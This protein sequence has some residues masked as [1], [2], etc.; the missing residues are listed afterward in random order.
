M[1]IIEVR[2][3]RKIFKS[4]ERGEGFIEATRSLFRRKKRILKAVNNVD[5]SIN[6]GEIVGFLGPNGA[7]KSTTIKIMSGVMYPDSGSVNIMGYVPWIDRK[8]YVANIGVVFG[9][10]SQLFWDLPPVDSFYLHKSIFS[11]EDDIFKEELEKLTKLLSI[12]DIMKKPTRQLS[13][14][15]RMRCEFV[16]AM[17]HK[18]RIVF[19]DEP[20]IGL[21]IFAKEIIRKFIKRTNK[22]EGTTFI[23]TSH[24]LEDIEHLCDRVIVINEGRIVF[25]D[26]T[27]KLKSENR[28]YVT[29]KFYN[30]VNLSKVKKIKNVK[31]IKKLSDYSL[32][33]E[34]DTSKISLNEII[35]VFGNGKKI[36]DLDISNPPITETIK[37]LYR[38]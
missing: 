35:S 2:E 18:P 14:G 38:A 17:L 3:L 11:V 19:L 25:N 21:D 24:D 29:I 5:F 13:L 34:V 20:T 28:K 6:E 23:I 32:K 16:M 1:K 31:I 22:K 33:L 8:K 10:K 37:K 12:N 7:G 4:Y 27:T 9:Q 15:E 26:K 30:K 36:E